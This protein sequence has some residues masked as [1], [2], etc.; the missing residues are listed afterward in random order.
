MKEE[1][2]D[3]GGEEEEQQNKEREEQEEEEQQQDREQK[4]ENDNN[5]PC[6]KCNLFSDEI[7]YCETCKITV[8]GICVEHSIVNMKY[9]G[10]SLERQF[11]ILQVEDKSVKECKKLYQDYKNSACFLWYCEN[12]YDENLPFCKKCAKKYN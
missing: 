1:Q 11:T 12:C 3:R 8:C 5:Y 2:Q 9:C 7:F 6:D 10:E 4:Q